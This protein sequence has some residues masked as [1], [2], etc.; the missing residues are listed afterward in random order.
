MQSGDGAKFPAVSFNAT[1]W[2]AGQN[3]T[4]ANAEII[5]VSAIATDTFTIAREQEGSSA[6]TIV[7]GDQIAATI[8]AKTL[9][10]AEGSS[11]VKSYAVTVADVANTATQ[12][13]TLS[14]T[15]PA[16]AMSDGDVLS[17]FCTFLLK[18]NKGTSGTVTVDMFWGSESVTVSPATTQSN[19]ATEQE[20]SLF[21]YATRVGSNLW[22]FK[23]IAF[24]GAQ[25]FPWGFSDDIVSRAAGS[26][27]NK[28]TAPTFSSDQTVALKITLSAADA[29][30]YWK[31]QTARVIKYGV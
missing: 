21:Y 19:S 29:A 20:V 14:F 22:I 25:I 16:N 9:T 27:N 31:T 30:F 2:P 11:P 6:R 23:T 12:T 18:N 4:T 8:T 26:Y 3:P 10:D 7:V 28:I 24:F 1:V 5:R 17:I 15:V 13:T